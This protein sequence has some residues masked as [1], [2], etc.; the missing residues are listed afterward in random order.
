MT[1]TSTCFTSRQ[2]GVR[3]ATRSTREINVCTR[4]IG[5]TTGDHPIFTTILTLSV[6]FGRPRRI[7][8]PTETG[9]SWSIAVVSATGGR[10]WSITQL[11]IRRASVARL[12]EANAERPTAPTIIMKV[13][14]DT[15]SVIGHS[16]NF[17]PRIVVNR[18]VRFSAT[19]ST[20]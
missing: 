2:C 3:L 15:H 20:L 9:A 13:S 6:D 11:A 7:Q 16:S 1:L 12:K 10:N 8:G 14:E 5:R 19:R 4:I 17:S 18:M